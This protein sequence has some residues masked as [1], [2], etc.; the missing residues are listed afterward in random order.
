MRRRRNATFGRV[1]REGSSRYRGSDRGDSARR[2]VERFLDVPGKFVLEN[3]TGY[4]TRDLAR[5]CARGYDALG[6]R[7]KIKILVSAAPQRSRGCA[8]VGGRRMSLSLASPSNYSLRRFARLFEHEATHLTGLDHKQMPHDVL[9]SLGSVPEWS[10]RRHVR[11]SRHLDHWARG[12]RLRYR[13]K[14]PDQLEMLARSRR[15][16][17]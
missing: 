16:T 10:H 1:K 4:D 14:A 13:H 8:D 2:T 3:Q 6:L 5:F 17:S 12:L 11:R 9:M 7:G 15:G